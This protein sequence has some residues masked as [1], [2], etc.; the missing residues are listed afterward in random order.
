[1]PKNKAIKNLKTNAAPEVSF[2]QSEDHA[3]LIRK[4]P[5][6]TQLE[7][8]ILED[9]QVSKHALMV[10]WVLCKHANR[11]GEDS[12]PSLNTI[13]QESRSGRTTV[14]KAVKEL[15]KLGYI[16]KEC[17]K[18]EDNPKVCTSNLYTILTQYKYE[19]AHSPS[20]DHPSPSQDHPS[21]NEVLEQYPPNNI[22]NNKKEPPS[23]QVHKSNEASKLE[24]L[25]TNL[26]IPNLKYHDKFD[27]IAI[28]LHEQGLLTQAYFDFIAKANP[29]AA[30][31]ITALK[32]GEC[33]TGYRSKPKVPG[34]NTCPDCGK[35]IP[36]WS[37]RCGWFLR[38]EGER[39]PA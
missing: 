20:Q 25:F 12:F 14:V 19:K 15:I 17:R 13:A 8:A 3:R 9:E 4:R 31:F 26:S 2:S 23:S 1:M 35:Q 21:P 11:D 5:P 38:P 37:C 36:G 29:E 18:R 27:T 10:Y 34:L 28:T 7:N 39:V 22:P 32:T 16:K 24:A 33:V 6:F 30:H